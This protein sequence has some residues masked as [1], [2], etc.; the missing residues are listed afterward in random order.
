MRT[1]L[2]LEPDVIQVAKEI[3]V[4]EKTTAGRVIS[5]LVRTA[6]GGAPQKSS[7]V[8]FVY[9]NG[10]PTLPPREGEIITL[11]HIQNLKDEED[12]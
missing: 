1:T 2:D 5:R 6:L 7:K 11:E 4:R 3:A 10:V 8:K 12:L 9:K